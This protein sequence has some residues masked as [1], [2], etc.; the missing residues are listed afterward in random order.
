MPEKEKYLRP[1]CPVGGRYYSDGNTEC[2]RGE[3]NS[4]IAMLTFNN[5]LENSM[6]TKP[7]NTLDRNTEC[8]RGEINS[9]I[10][11]FIAIK[12]LERTTQSVQEVK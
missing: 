8:T 9:S 1:L 4:S 12:N 3:I 6:T 2:T 11:M 5:E 7:K 10:A